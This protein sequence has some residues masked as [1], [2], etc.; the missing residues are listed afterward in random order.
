MLTI[1][2]GK[3]E[4]GND[5]EVNGSKGESGTRSNKLEPD[6]HFEPKLL[7]CFQTNNLK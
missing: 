4:L 5:M 3:A 6:L 2:T 1:L 7:Y